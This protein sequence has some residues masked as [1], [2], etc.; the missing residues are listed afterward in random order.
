M[1]FIFLVLICSMAISCE[2]PT[3]GIKLLDKETFSTTIKD[4]KVTLYTLTNN[5]GLVSEITNL[6]GR[7]VSLWVPDKKGRLT[8][9]NIGLKTAQEYTTS[10]SRYYGAIIGRYGNRI[11]NGAFS[12]DSTT[13]HL[14]SNNGENSLHGGPTGYFDR[15]WNAKQTA[16]NRLELSYLSAD[17]EEGYPGNLNIKVIYELTYQNELKIEYFATTDKTTHINLTNHNYY[18][19]A[20]EGSGSI[21]QHILYIN[22]NSYTPVNESLIPSGEIVPVKDTPFDFTSATRIG[23]RINDPNIQLK[24]GAGYDHNWVLNKKSDT[25]SLAAIIKEPISGRVMEVLTNEPGLQFYSG[26]FLDG[27]DTGKHGKSITYRSAF[28][29]ETQHFP[30]SP[31]KPQFPSTLLEPGKEY[32]SICIY[33]F[34]TE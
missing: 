13:Y 10:K 11:A 2:P 14:N 4:N 17:M 22:A 8:D 23:E 6:G 24:Y 30:D 18:N 29:L 20:G 32:Y 19:L 26:N 9:I 21:T 15:I 27:T 25:L 16:K 7:V 5:K 28:C 3:S 31:N 12:I 34:K 1:K 33:R